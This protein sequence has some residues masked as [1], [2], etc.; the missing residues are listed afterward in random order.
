MYKRHQLF[1]FEKCSLG[2]EMGGRKCEKHP[3][4]HLDLV[5]VCVCVGGG[6]GG[7]IPL[8]KT[9]KITERRTSVPDHTL[10]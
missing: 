10:P 1:C 3:V 9:L 8:L 2:E 4:G 7:G 5:I 6:G